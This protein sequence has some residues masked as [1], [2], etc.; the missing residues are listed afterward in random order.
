[1]ENWA[2]VYGPDQIKASFDGEKIT[3]EVSGS[4]SRRDTVMG[5]CKEESFTA[6]K[7]GHG[8][9]A[10]GQYQ[11]GTIY[12]R[13]RDGQVLIEHTQWGEWAYPTLFEAL[14][15]ALNSQSNGMIRLDEESSGL[16][17]RLIEA[18]RKQ[19][20]VY[21]SSEAE[22]SRIAEILI[23]V[24]ARTGKSPC[25]IDAME[26]WRHSGED[27]PTRSH[28]AA[29]AIELAHGKEQEARESVSPEWSM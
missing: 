7:I 26:F 1:M 6:K 16:I 13:I 21:A 9:S 19:G 10:C 2:A 12:L 8:R 25:A 15:A 14:E 11:E 23:G 20:E 27:W 4:F 24:S 29:R 28:I 18:L 3:I 5:F 22:A 17:G